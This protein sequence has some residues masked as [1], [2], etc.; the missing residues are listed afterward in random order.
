M[1]MRC[2]R[3]GT[4]NNLR[5]RTNNQG[6]CKNCNHP[7]AFEPSAVTN[8]KLKFTDPFFA[9][10][11]NDISDQNR[12]YFTP[13]QLF[14]LLD[15]RLKAKVDTSPI[16]FGCTFV[17]MTI[18]IAIVVGSLG[19]SI[20][21][22]LGLSFLISGIIYANRYQNGKIKPGKS[23]LI[24]QAQSQDWITR[25]ETIN[26]KSK[27]LPSPRSES[28]NSEISPE[29]SAY[30]FDRVVICDNTAIAQ[31]LIANNFHFE[32]SCAVLSITGYP[33]SIFST[34]LDMLRRNL[35]LKVYALHDA[36]PSGVSLVHN[37]RT[38]PDWFLNSNA[39]IYDLGLLPRQ[40]FSSRSVF[41]RN[42]TESAQSAKQLPEEVRRDLTSEELKW[43]DAGKF[44]ELESFSPQRIIRVANQGIAKS[45]APDSSDS[46]ILID[47]G[48]DSV[49]VIE[50]FG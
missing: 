9:K 50:S 25:W 3:C 39:V 1:G 28:S 37:L 49:Y 2:V 10:V 14:Y 40:I 17:V 15:R 18:I 46:L 36:S 34:V 45:Q 26:G 30:S 43:L 23:F 38:S 11:I 32:N 47:S 44:V 29:I 33:E 20:I 4:D 35:D 12:L 22:A 6:R 42:S 31:M 21:P 13:K 8:T 24:S 48:A 41:V 5:D 19:G 16:C 27:M 7:F